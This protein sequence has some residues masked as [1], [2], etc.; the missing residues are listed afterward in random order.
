M[1]LAQNQY[2]Q[3]VEQLT[4]KIPQPVTFENLK[5]EG[6]TLLLNARTPSGKEFAQFLTQLFTWEDLSEVALRDARL[7]SGE[8]IDF[9]LEV[10]IKPE[11]YRFRLASGQE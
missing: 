4:Q 10:K 2:S 7:S 8:G 5:L 11:S 9:N 3:T 6:N 1:K